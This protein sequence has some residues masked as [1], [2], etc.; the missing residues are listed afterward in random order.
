MFYWM[1]KRVL[2]FGAFDIIHP[3]HIF[4]LERA[5]RLGSEL[6]VVVARDSSIEREK[7][8]P[9]VN[10]E[11]N[12]LI[13]VRALKPV[14]RAVL[15]LKTGSRLRVIAREKPQVIALGHDQAVTRS[16][17]MRFLRENEMKARVVRMPPFKRR[18]YASTAVRKKISLG[19]DELFP[20]Q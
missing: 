11:K 5:R 3:G 8:H 12:R 9:P 1:K 10:D 4:Y 18:K 17:V 2:A 16:E 15:G 6:V 14:D 13:V 19:I 7:G 20:L